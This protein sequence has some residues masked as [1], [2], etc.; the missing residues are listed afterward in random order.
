L[1][2]GLRS[3]LS[4]GLCVPLALPARATRRA[5]LERLA[6]AR[7]VPL[8]KRAIDGLADGIQGGVPAL[9][10]AIMELEFAAQ[11]DGSVLDTKR[12]QQLVAA[13][14]ADKAP[15]LREIAGSTAKYFGLKLAD[16]KSPLRQRALVAARGVAMYLARQLTNHSFEQIGAFFGGRAHTTVLHGYRRMEKLVRQDRAMREAVGE[17]KKL[18]QPS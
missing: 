2:A 10:S 18:L 12:V 8:P 15:T 13:G 16:L 3:R 11:H 7:G 1:L 6:K 9:L 14:T 17:L 5:I 4:A